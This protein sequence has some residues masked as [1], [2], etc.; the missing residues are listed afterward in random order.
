M[1]NNKNDERYRW[2]R[3]AGLLGTIPFLL[4]IPPIA[5]VLIGNWL[6]GKLGTSPAFTIVLV[7]LGFIA[8]IREVATV[9]KKASV[10]SERDNKRD[11]KTDDEP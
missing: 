9:I 4:A 6:D 3:Q 5:G 8:G 11:R 2:A 10:D 1:T 7:I